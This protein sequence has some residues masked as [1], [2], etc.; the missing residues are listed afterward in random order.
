MTD[1]SLVGRIRI[2]S[3]H[4][5][6]FWCSAS[7]ITVHDRGEPWP[8]HSALLYFANTLANLLLGMG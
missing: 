6:G 1:W 5:A 3:L 8:M 4:A 7:L 2:Q